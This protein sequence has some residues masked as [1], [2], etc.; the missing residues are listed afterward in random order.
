MTEEKVHD[1]PEFVP[2]DHGFSLL[3]KESFLFATMNNS[4]PSPLM[5]NFGLF[6]FS[7]PCWQAGMNFADNFFPEILFIG[8]GVVLVD[9]SERTTSP[10]F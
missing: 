2:G 5:S 1:R 10:I 9:A 6:S 4:R 7:V 3:M 8:G